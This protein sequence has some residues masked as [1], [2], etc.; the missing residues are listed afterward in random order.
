MPMV[1]WFLRELA[2]G[3]AWMSDRKVLDH[4]ARVSGAPAPR[5]TPSADRRPLVNKL[6]AQLAAG[7]YNNAYADAMA[8]RMYHVAR[9]EWCNPEQLRGLVAA[10]EYNARRKRAKTTE[11]K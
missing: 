5:S 8:R 3:N 2:E 10:L 9:H 6:R 11:A 1:W 7:G 4:L